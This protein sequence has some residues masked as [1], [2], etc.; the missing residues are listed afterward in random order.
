MHE[1]TSIWE[2]TLNLI[3]VEVPLWATMMLFFFGTVVG[4]F[5]REHYDHSS[6]PA[7]GFLETLVQVTVLSLWALA[8]ARGVFVEGAE[9]PPLFLNLV[10]GAVVGSM[11]K[12]I[13]EYLIKAITSFKK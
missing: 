9:Y 6:K 5:L 2:T 11:N 3:L 12:Q 4:W 13:G 1:G 10:F 7:R 8:T